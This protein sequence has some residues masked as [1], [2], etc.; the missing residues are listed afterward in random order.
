M[1]EVRNT[2]KILIGK[3]EGEKRPRGRHS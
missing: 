3:T 2:Y 1:D